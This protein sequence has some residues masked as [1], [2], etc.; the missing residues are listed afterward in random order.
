MWA[1]RYVYCQRGTV[2][3][4]GVQLAGSYWQQSCVM[5]LGDMFWVLLVQVRRGYVRQTR[6]TLHSSTAVCAL[7]DRAAPPPILCSSPPCPT[8][9][10]G[11]LTLAI[12]LDAVLPD[13]N[14]VRR[15]PWFFLLP[16]TWWRSSGRGSLRASARALGEPTE[17]EAGLTVDADVAEESQLQRAR[18]AAY[19][20]AASGGA[21]LPAEA[22]M[23]PAQLAL[24]PSSPAR[25][26]ASAAPAAAGG[27]AKDPAAAVDERPYAVE[28]FGLRKVYSRGGLLRRR[29]FVAVRGNWLG[30]HQ[31]AQGCGALWTPLWLES[32][33]PSPSPPQ[34]ASASAYW[35]PTARER[36]P[37]STV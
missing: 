35:A 17:A 2:L 6:V 33:P 14:G 7:L 4:S 27:K 11:F 21:A 26:G 30:V 28:M 10:A 9:C 1:D 18:C 12:Y 20:R 24:M 32:Q 13:A 3:P 15:P 25:E 37:P 31:G 22:A 23:L 36:V 34:Q 16:S 29:P 19:L 5:P 8:Q